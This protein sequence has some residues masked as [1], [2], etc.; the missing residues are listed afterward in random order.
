MQIACLLAHG[1][2]VCLHCI[3]WCAAYCAV[4]TL[5]HTSLHFEAH[6][7]SCE[8]TRPALRN[9]PSHIIIALL[10]SYCRVKSGR[11]T[12]SL[13]PG[14][15]HALR[16][17][18]ANEFPEYVRFATAS[19]ANTPFAVKCA[20]AALR[21][22]EVH[23]GV[24]VYEVLHRG[25]DHDDDR[26]LQIGR[27][28]PLSPDKRTHFNRLNSLLGIDFEHMVFFDDCNWG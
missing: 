4:V 23:P 9:K 16:K 15:V 11:A 25:W 3:V 17:L 24:S 6:Q 8:L 21:A 5:A 7:T 13:H 2:L 1:L 10:V 26:H 18:W 14:A 22:L 19:S 27:S 20:H 12:V 28:K